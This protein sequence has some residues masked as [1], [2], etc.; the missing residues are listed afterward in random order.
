MNK[1]IQFGEGGFL[2]GFC[3][4]MVQLCND[5]C[6]WNAEITVVQPIPQGMCDA[7][8]AKDCN[9]THICR[10]LEGVQKTEVT[11]ISRCVKPYD[12]FEG[13]LKLAE[14]KDFRFIFSNTTEAG[15]V[16]DPKDR[17]TDTPANSFPGKLTQLLLRRYRLGL[18]GFIL[19]PCELIDR[20]GDNLKKCILQY[21][22]LWNAEDGFKAWINEENIFCNTLV[23]RI[24]TGCPED[25]EFP[26][27]ASEYFHLWVIEGCP[28]LFREFPLDQCGLNVLLTDDLEMYRTRKVRILNGAHTSTVLYGLLEGLETVKDCIDDPK[29]NAHLRACIFEEII[30][31]LDLPKEELEAYAEDVLTRFANP[32]IRHLLSSIALNSVSKFKVRVLPSILEYIK[33]YDKMP[34]HLLLAFAKLIEFYRTDKTNDDAVITA[35]MQTATV[36]EILSNTALWGEDLG[37]LTNEVTRYVDP[38]CR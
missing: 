16:F 6:D 22:D 5:Q 9:Y 29:M 28:D 3:D 19:L 34:E 8:T 15:I 23:D 17:M 32:Y 21:A 33:R 12:D 4:W 35:F 20:N 36:E 30:P 27:N 2:R 25:E 38:S 26:T 24:N 14:E 37:F 31:T 7:L 10:G 11:C 1:I 13:Y 18:P